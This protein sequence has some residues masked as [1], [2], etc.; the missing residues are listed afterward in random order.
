MPMS[1]LTYEC[2]DCGDTYD[3]FAE[4]VDCEQGHAEV[5]EE[6]ARWERWDELVE[7]VNGLETCPSPKFLD[8]LSATCWTP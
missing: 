6:N 2:D 1:R 3:T 7:R 4:A 8:T 5:V